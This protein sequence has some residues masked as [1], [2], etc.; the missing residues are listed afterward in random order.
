VTRQGIGFLSFFRIGTWSL[1]LSFLGA[2]EFG[3]NLRCVTCSL[4]SRWRG[5]VSGNPEGRL[6]WGTRLWNALC[7][8]EESNG[9]LMVRFCWA[10]FGALGETLCSV[11]VDYR[12]GGGHSFLMSL[13]SALD[14]GNLGSSLVL[15]PA[16][17]GTVLV[18]HHGFISSDCDF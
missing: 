2:F 14:W 15:L 12:G 10:L 18:K 5:G 17:N 13:R 8:L 11:S 3:G 16:T 7:S 9:V 1:R 6:A 4:R